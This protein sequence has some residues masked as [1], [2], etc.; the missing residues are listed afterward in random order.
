[1]PLYEFMCEK[2][3]TAKEVI[4]KGKDHTA[5]TCPTCQTSMTRQVGKSSFTLKGTGWFKDGYK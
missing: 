4:V 3:L 5:P 1:M 2:C